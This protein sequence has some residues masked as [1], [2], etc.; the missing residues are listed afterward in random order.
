MPSGPTQSRSV[1]GCPRTVTVD[2]AGVIT[3]DR[4][5]GVLG[6]TYAS[7]AAVNDSFVLVRRGAA[8]GEQVTVTFQQLGSSAPATSVWYG[9]SATPRQTPWGSA[10]FTLG[11][12]PIG[13]ANSC[14]RV[15]V[16]GVDTGLVLAIGP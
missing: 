9:V 11:V 8:A 12:K 16:D 2:P 3:G 14:W 15:L 1:A 4:A 6:D 10:T 5:F 7:W 13:F